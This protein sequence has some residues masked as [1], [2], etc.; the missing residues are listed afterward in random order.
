MATEAS[1][2]LE[3]GIKER[4]SATLSS[5]LH[6]KRI[7]TV[8]YIYMEC[9]VYKRMETFCGVHLYLS[10]IAGCIVFCSNVRYN[11]NLYCTTEEVDVAQW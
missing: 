3:F 1:W 5:H 8:F 4:A 7:E 9:T 11:S 2:R 6:N 10:A